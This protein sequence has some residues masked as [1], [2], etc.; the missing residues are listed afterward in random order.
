MSS[1]MLISQ[2][3]WFTHFLPLAWQNSKRIWKYRQSCTNKGHFQAWGMR[4]YIIDS[5][6]NINEC[7]I[8][9]PIKHKTRLYSLIL[10]EEPKKST[11]ARLLRYKQ[12]NKQEKRLLKWQ[13][14]RQEWKWNIQGVDVQCNT[15]GW[16]RHNHPLTTTSTRTQKERD[17]HIHEWERQN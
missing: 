6:F 3:T 11:R 5:Q 2:F 7:E 17:T 1:E 13:S 4:Q 12:C 15:K 8:W 9:W 10:E 14:P 16:S